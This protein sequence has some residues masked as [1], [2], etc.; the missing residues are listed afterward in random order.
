[1]LTDFH[2][3]SEVSQDSSAKMRDM[4][5]AEAEYGIER[6]C[7]TDHCD[8]VNWRDY[9][10]NESCREVP[11]QEL[12][13]HREMLASFGGR[14]PI[15]VGAG[16]ELGEPLFDTELAC[17][18]AKA[19]GLDFVLGSLH[20]L[21]AHGDVWFIEYSSPE[22]CRRVLNDYLDELL[23][24]AELDFF[25]VMAHIGYP[26]RCMRQSGF[27]ICMTVGEYGEKIERIL[28]L[29]IDKGQGIEI[30]CS[31]IRDG[32]ES[33]PARDVLTLYR[34]LGGELITTGSD[35]HS[36]RNAAKCIREGQELLRECGFK[37]TCAFRQRRAE[38]IK[39]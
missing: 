4:V 22:H 28:R 15:E 14:P 24:I 19:E 23:K 29:L 9:S 32:G 18:L 2:T 37:Y 7:F 27:D 3:H 30:N 26:V 1:M 21:R 39:L 8:M 25:D 13:R 33:F 35:A 31:G 5:L 11:A 6:M 38:F 34:S 10:F 20:I 12:L 36:P 17:E 16:L